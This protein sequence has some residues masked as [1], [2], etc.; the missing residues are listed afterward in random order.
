MLQSSLGINALM[1]RLLPQL[2]QVGTCFQ[3]TPS[4]QCKVMELH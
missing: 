1:H 3:T 4:L 2:I